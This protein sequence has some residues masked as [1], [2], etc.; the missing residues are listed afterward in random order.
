MS[1]EKVADTTAVDIA[2]NGSPAELICPNGNLLLHGGN[3]T[4]EYFS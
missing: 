3:G 1:F 4:I 2:V